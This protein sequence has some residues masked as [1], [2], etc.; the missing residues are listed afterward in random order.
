MECPLCDSTQFKDYGKTARG[1]KKYQ[2][3]VCHNIFIDGTAKTFC[4]PEIN[5]LKFKK[6]QIFKT[7][8][9]TKKILIIEVIAIIL[10]WLVSIV[11]SISVFNRPLNIDAHHEWLSAHTL[12]SLRAL[13]QW[14]IHHLLGASVL[15]PKSLEY[16][17]ADITT[18]N[19]DDGIYL[20]YPSLWL[21]VPYII[22]KISSIPI[23]VANLQIYNL[24][25]ERLLNSIVIY[26]LCLEILRL[27][28]K[29]DFINIWSSKILAFLATFAW[30]FNPPVLYWSQNVYFC[31]QAVLLP[32]YALILFALK[33]RFRFENLTRNQKLILFL[34]SLF[35]AGFDWYGWVFLFLLMLSVALPLVRKDIWLAWSSVQP[36]LGAIALITVWFISQ[37]IYYQDGWNQI[38][39]IF[40][41]RVGAK[42]EVNLNQDIF[43]MTFYWVKY[44]PTYMQEMWETGKLSILTLFLGLL[45]LLCWLWWH[46]QYK[47]SL[48]SVFL[49]IF[50]APFLQ[51]A[52]L[53]QH[54][55][56]HDFSAFKLA[57]PTIFA[58]W[59]VVPVS[60]LILLQ[61][62]PKSFYLLSWLVLGLLIYLS[63]LISGDI[64][65]EFIEFAGVGRTYPR[66]IGA[67]IS[68]YIADND[69]PISDSKYIYA[70]SVPPQPT[71]Y[72]NRFVYTTLE[73]PNLPK[74]LNLPSLKHLNFV[75]LIYEDEKPNDQI[76]EACQNS[77]Q[78]IPETIMSRRVRL[79]RSEKLQNLL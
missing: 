11:F 68:K 52:I 23:T 44:L 58:I 3:E 30:M 77:W 70:G 32:I 13:E 35:A 49:L 56:I 2:C 53:R 48:L 16:I 9:Q 51:I 75:Y 71:W 29:I 47:L 39:S 73:L 74:K 17:Q 63:I 12:V 25:F 31:D 59:I 37:L 33:Q 65:S 72:T 4:L 8:Y 1:D 60:I 66:E 55:T 43:V 34:L 15:I 76:N 24:I 62:L 20:S 28:E 69:L 6:N 36:I 78:D 14:G 21:V 10:L 5:L 40:L 46:S 54:S 18:L 22:F 27:F 41:E 26:F 50:L 19:K 79:C 61:Y 38:T 57:L 42:M 64:S 7:T 45:I 67:I